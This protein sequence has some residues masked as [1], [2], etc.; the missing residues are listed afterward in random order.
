MHPKPA[1]RDLRPHKVVLFV[2][3]LTRAD[4]LV[5][6]DPLES[7]KV[8]PLVDGR[9]ELSEVADAFRYVEEGHARGKIVVTL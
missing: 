2:A 5:L 6:S 4:L 9:Y 1:H 7:G 3:K 8:K